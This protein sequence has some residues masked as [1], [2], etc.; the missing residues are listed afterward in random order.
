[1]L[2]YDYPGACDTCSILGCPDRKQPNKDWWVA[3]HDRLKREEDRDNPIFDFEND[4]RRAAILDCKRLRSKGM[5]I[6]DTD[7]LLKQGES[8]S[9]VYRGPLDRYSTS[10][11]E[12]PPKHEYIIKLQF[13]YDVTPST[14]YTKEFAVYDI[15][16][17]E[18]H[19]QALNKY[20]NSI[21]LDSRKGE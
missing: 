1:M 5:G 12:G 16:W 8:P 18:A 19:A 11:K 17:D 14:K 2:D 4:L 9:E 6:Y 3:H 10:E 13:H 20:P 15:G 7:Q 21:L